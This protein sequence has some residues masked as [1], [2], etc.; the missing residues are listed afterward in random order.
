MTLHIMV[1]V[2]DYKVELS[3]ALE[4][5]EIYPLFMRVKIKEIFMLI[6]QCDC[7]GSLHQVFEVYFLEDGQTVCESC[8][9]TVILPKRYI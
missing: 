3:M 4:G 6:K 2:M 5:G 1:S 9:R 7:C 8:M